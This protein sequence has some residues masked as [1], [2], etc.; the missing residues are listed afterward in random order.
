[1]VPPTPTTFPALLREARTH[2]ERTF[3]PRR[4]ANLAEPVTFGALAADV[5]R[6]AMALLELGIGRGDRVGLI[7]ENRYEWLLID[8]ALPDGSGID[9][10]REAS[11]TRPDLK[12]IVVSIFGDAQSV[13]N[14]IEAGAHGYLLKGADPGEAADAI[15]AVL[16][17]GAPISPAVA[18]HIL[19]RI[20]GRATLSPPTSPPI[21]SDKEIAILTELAKGF[22]YKEV[23]RLHVGIDRLPEGDNRHALPGHQ[24]QGIEDVNDDVLVAR[25]DL[26]AGIKTAG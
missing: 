25:M 2:S 1:M 10:I 16:A 9:L 11:A 8:L 20:R 5:D 7:A 13:V 12:I 19:A 15:R 26:A 6:L 3:L 17:G 22:R 14:A 4:R 23:A 21:L 24:R 18:G